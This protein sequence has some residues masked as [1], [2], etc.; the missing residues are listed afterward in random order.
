MKL[1]KPLSVQPWQLTLAEHLDRQAS[2]IEQAADERAR[3]IVRAAGRFATRYFDQ[4]RSKIMAEAAKV[5]TDRN[6]INAKMHRK[7]VE[8]AIAKHKPIPANVLAE[9]N[10]DRC[11]N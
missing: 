10:A 3:E 1:T 11:R 7:L 9:F 2:F 6:G 4:E 8:L 5:R